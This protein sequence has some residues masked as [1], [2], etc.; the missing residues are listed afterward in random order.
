M[1]S[2][3]LIQHDDSA[4]HLFSP[5]VG[6][7]KALSPSGALVE[8]DQIVGQIQTLNQT[9]SLRMPEGPV[10]RI[11]WSQANPSH[12]AVGYGEALG[13]WTPASMQDDESNTSRKVAEQGSAYQAPME[14][15]FYCRADPESGPFITEGQTLNPGDQVGLIEVMKTFYP[16]YFE[17]T[18]AQTIQAIKVKDAQAVEMGTTLFLLN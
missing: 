1:K 7:F 8:S 13:T 18:K 11:E 15:L 16:I 2:Y 9:F 12:L 5:A 10:G 6:Y 3:T 14:G 17:G 4:P